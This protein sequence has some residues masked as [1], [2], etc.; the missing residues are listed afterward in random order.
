M[1]RIHAPSLQTIENLVTPS[2]ARRP[3]HVSTTVTHLHRPHMAIDDL[4]RHSARRPT[5]HALLEVDVTEVRDRM[6]A[7]AEGHHPTMT[8]FVLSSI[9]RAVR[10]CPEVNARRAGRHVVHFDEVDIVATVE[11]EIDGVVVPVPFVVQ[12]ADD[13]SVESIAAELRADRTIPLSRHDDGRAG[14]MLA[15]LP[16]SMR[17][18]GATVFGHFPRAA[19][20]FGPPIGVSSVGMFGVGWGIPV[21]PMTLMATMGGV[22]TRPVFELG[23]VFNHEFLPL[24]LSFDHS[25]IDGAPA[26]RFS[27]K[28]RTLMETAAVFDENG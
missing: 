15:P 27:T 17:R 26:A 24:T 16:R 4:I 18:L 13:K 23:H 6:R 10:E 1:N 25:L 21:S 28:L 11:R 9:A 5:V 8:A 12:D 14:S 2:A 22:C 19:A 7:V 3:Y 20:R